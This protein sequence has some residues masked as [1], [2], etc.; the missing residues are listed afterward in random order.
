M[1]EPT[2][3]HSRTMDS[4]FTWQVSPFV[5]GGEP[6]LLVIQHDRKRQSAATLDE[7]VRLIGAAAP[8][9]AACSRARVSG[10][11]AVEDG[12]RREALRMR[13]LDAEEAIHS[14]DDNNFTGR[15]EAGVEFMSNASHVRFVLVSDPSAPAVTWKPIAHR[16][17]ADL[18]RNS[19]TK[20]PPR[21][22]RYKWS[23][24]ITPSNSTSPMNAQHDESGVERSVAAH[25]AGIEQRP[26]R[27][28]GAPGCSCIH[29]EKTR[30]LPC[31]VSPIRSG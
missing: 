21:H 13:G 22:R 4:T 16:L 19:R 7:A 5:F 27:K 8:S 2:R 3:R 17:D 9:P 24:S 30:P 23:W 26:R 29:G 28:D 20:P 31:S 15:F 10:S 18:H 12:R 6:F 25:A 11:A 1:P 14:V